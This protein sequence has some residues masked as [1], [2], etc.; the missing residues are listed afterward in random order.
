MYIFYLDGSIDRN[1]E[2]NQV[3]S[4]RITFYKDDA[5]ELINSFLYDIG[6]HICGHI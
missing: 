3:W 4:F 6:F 1:Y 5:C 2:C